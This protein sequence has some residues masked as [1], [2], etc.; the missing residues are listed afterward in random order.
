[1]KRTLQFKQDEK[2]YGI[3]EEDHLLFLIP[4]PELQFDVKEFYEAF[5][6]DGKDYENIGIENCIE[7]DKTA[8]RTFETIQKLISLIATK[9]NEA[10]SAINENKQK[11]SQTLE[12]AKTGIGYLS[13]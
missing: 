1:M 4:V 13:L 6:S 7:N 2:G 12:K 9:L 5:Y 10:H 3:F 8:K 11:D